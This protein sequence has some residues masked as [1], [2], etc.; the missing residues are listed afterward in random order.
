MAWIAILTGGAWLRFHDLASRPFHADE[1]VNALKLAELRESGV[2]RYDPHHYHGNTL[3]IL[4]HGFLQLHP[5]ADHKQPSEDSLRSFSALTGWLILFIPLACRKTLGNAASLAWGII[6]SGSPGLL[7]INR[8]YIHESLFILCTI[9]GIACMEMASRS[10]HTVAWA[11]AAGVSW[12][13]MVSTKESWPLVLF[14]LSVGYGMTT[15]LLKRTQPHDPARPGIRSPILGWAIGT[16]LIS[17]VAMYSSWGHHPLGVRDALRV[18][19][20]YENDPGHSKPWYYFLR[21]LFGS[22]RLGRWATA[23]SMLIPFIVMG[24]YAVARNA[25]KHPTHLSWAIATLA[26][27][28]IHSVIPY[29]TPWLMTLPFVGISF[30]A[31]IGIQWFLECR[32]PRSLLLATLLILSLIWIGSGYRSAI[33]LPEHRTNRYSYSPTS[34]DLVR[35]VEQIERIASIHPDHGSIP[36]DVIFPEGDN[37]W[38]LPWYLRDY[39]NTAWRISIPEQIRTPI[40]ITPVDMKEALTHNMATDYTCEMRGL[41]AGMILCLMIRQDLWTKLMESRNNQIDGPRPPLMPSGILGD[42]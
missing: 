14:C 17:A 42:S 5:G 18:F 12:G 11:I 24:C 10:R 31:A 37:Y 8:S 16:A 34:P 39:K 35:M 22:E 23:E 41:R 26:L 21:L 27:I 1:A 25:T 3:W 2:A 33:L 13:L 28:G 4:S 32:I 36:I 30:I 6:L 7:A 29:K 19:F 20:I 38:P 40:V 15:L 9:S